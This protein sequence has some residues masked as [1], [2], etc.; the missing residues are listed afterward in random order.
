MQQTEKVGELKTECRHRAERISSLSTEIK[1][2]AERISSL[3]T[4]N[5][6]L[7]NENRRLQRGIDNRNHTTAKVREVPPVSTRL[8]DPLMMHEGDYPV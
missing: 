2:Q 6:R 8:E 5:E 1:R 3:S 4:E 7:K